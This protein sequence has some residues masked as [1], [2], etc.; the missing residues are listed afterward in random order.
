MFGELLP[1]G[2]PATEAVAQTPLPVAARQR[3]T[4]DSSAGNVG[5][6]CAR[7]E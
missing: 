2:F 6:R 5:F 7:D 3:L 4:P 1:D